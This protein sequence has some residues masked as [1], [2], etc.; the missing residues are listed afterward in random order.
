MS[1]LKMS[2]GA[3]QCLWVWDELL[4]SP[5]KL[6]L[7]VDGICQFLLFFSAGRNGVAEC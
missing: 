5:W 2:L 7:L 4:L 3:L 1:N 6:P